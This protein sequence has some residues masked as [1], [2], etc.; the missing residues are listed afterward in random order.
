MQ[1]KLKQIAFSGV[2]FVGACGT[3]NAQSS[4][5]WERSP[6]PPAASGSP[7]LSSPQADGTK[8]ALD[9]Y[10]LPGAAVAPPSPIQNASH[11]EFP[12]DQPVGSRSPIEPPAVQGVVWDAL[13][14]TS[15]P[16]ATHT[17]AARQGGQLSNLWKSADVKPASTNTAID[18]GLI[19]PIDSM[20]LR[21]TTL[22]TSPHVEHPAPVAEPAAFGL[23]E[24]YRPAPAPRTEVEEFSLPAVEQVI[25]STSRPWS[26]GPRERASTAEASTSAA[27]AVEIA[28][29]VESTSLIPM[30]LIPTSLAIE[31]SS[32]SDR[33]AALPEKLPTNASAGPNGYVLQSL[34]TPASVGAMN[35]TVIPIDI[36]PLNRL[37]TIPPLSANAKLTTEQMTGPLTN[38]PALF[39]KLNIENDFRELPSM[40]GS[41]TRVE[42]GPSGLGSG[43]MRQDYAWVT[44]TF[45]HRPLYFEQENLERYGIGPQRHAQPIHSAAHFFMSVALMPYKLTTQHPCEK[46]YTL[47]HNRPGDCV[48]YQ[49]RSLLGQSYPWEACRYFES[50]SVYR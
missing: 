20:P 38:A 13:P 7:A 37:T 1:C 19:G 27:A 18:S 2:L 32:P 33:M 14:R 11:F 43:W 31:E 29:P 28:E 9:W 23:I 12:K 6:A 5:S 15:N 35:E 47:G 10:Q 24:S 3:C 41:R 34:R 42:T 17:P 8:R 50:Y 16:Q 30:S 4:W 39:G 26:T 22:F 25:P 40:A 48:P 44:P 21:S 45:H 46:V 49:G 36:L